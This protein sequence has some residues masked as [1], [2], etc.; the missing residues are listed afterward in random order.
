MGFE[1]VSNSTNKYPHFEAGIPQQSVTASS[2]DNSLKESYLKA[3]TGNKSIEDVIPQFEMKVEEARRIR[4]PIQSSVALDKLIDSVLSGGLPT[5]EI[6]D[7]V[8]YIGMLMQ[9]GDV[10]ATSFYEASMRLIAIGAH[11][12]FPNEAKGLAHEIW[13]PALRTEVN[14]ILAKDAVPSQTA[15][16]SHAVPSKTIVIL[17]EP[18]TLGTVDA[19]SYMQSIRS[20][21]EKARRV[22]DPKQSSIDLA[23]LISKTLKSGLSA[24]DMY[25]SVREIGMY[26][27]ILDVR[28][29]AFSEATMQ[30][31]AAG[32][33]QACKAQAQ[34]L[35]QQITCPKQ[36]SELK[37][38]IAQPWVSPIKSSDSPEK[39]P[40]SSFENTKFSSIPPLE[41]IRSFEFTPIP[42]AFSTTTNADNQT[43]SSSVSQ[44]SHPSDPLTMSYFEKR[45]KELL[46]ETER[47]DTKK[48]N[49]ETSQSTALKTSG[50]QE[51]LESISVTE[52]P[53]I[54]PSL[55]LR[56]VATILSQGMDKH[57]Q[58]E[59]EN[60]SIHF[61]IS[62][63]DDSALEK[64][65]QEIQKNADVAQSSAVKLPGLQDQ[66]Q[67]TK[68]MV[69]PTAFNSAST[70]VKSITQEEELKKAKQEIDAMM[71]MGGVD[72]AKTYAQYLKFPTNRRAAMEYIEAKSK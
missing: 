30:M 13:H 20:D 53:T 36:R 49:T 32:A 17:A 24:S 29:Q 15:P 21:I 8:K 22:R 23:A 11:K 6:Y 55:L 63:L 16:S 54:P 60:S 50:L 66:L 34:E 44:S 3:V 57:E 1:N 69:M 37:E 19:K 52:M 7:K 58:V 67:N 12:E 4:D 42:A 43:S 10:R 31:A 38:V 61:S 45:A 41:P 9:S 27:Q 39:I 62:D 35:V 5:K 71:Q 14:K 56:P 48:S 25:R 2:A 33:H 40:V 68:G 72:L 47:M 65:L 59:E 28:N 26:M 18:A 51:Q 64:Q 46:G 70:A